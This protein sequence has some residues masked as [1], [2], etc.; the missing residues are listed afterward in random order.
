MTEIAERGL[1]LLSC[2]MHLSYEFSL[3][4]YQ[5]RERFSR[6]REV[7]GWSKSLRGIRSLHIGIVQDSCLLFNRVGEILERTLKET[8]S[9]TPRL[10]AS[11]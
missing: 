11:A 5:S 6:F 9:A 4:H 2:Q 8:R 1:H 10:T 3:Y 7:S